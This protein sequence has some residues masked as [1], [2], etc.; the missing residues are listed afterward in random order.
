VESDPIAKEALESK[1]KEFKLKKQLI[2]DDPNEK[3]LTD[4]QKDAALSGLSGL[5]INA[6][7]ITAVALKKSPIPCK[8]SYSNHIS[9]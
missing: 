9:S 3:S 2:L 5:I 7:V 6:S 4:E 1:L 8:S